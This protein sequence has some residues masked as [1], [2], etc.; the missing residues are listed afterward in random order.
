[1]KPTLIVHGGAG[2]FPQHHQETA[3]EG[4]RVAAEKGYELL[5]AGSSALDIVET[6]VCILED[7]PVFDSGVGSV[8]NSDGE[9]EQ[10]AIIMD[11]ATLGIGA[12]AAVKG[13]RNA[14]TLAR[15]VKDHTPHTLLVGDGA[16]RFARQQKLPLCTTADLTTPHELDRYLAHLNNIKTETGSK[17]TVGAVAVDKVGNI[18]AATSTGGIFFKMPGRVGDTPIVGAGAYADNQLGGASATGHGESIMR[19]LLSKTALDALTRGM[20]VQQAAE[21][22]IHVLHTRMQAQ[23]GIIMVDPAGN[24]GFAYNTPHMAVARVL[25]DGH[26][27]TQL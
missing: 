6:A 21:F 3:M 16:F 11:G 10:D 20:N 13:I 2:T 23:A 14:I 19:I 27:E 4:V 12:V 17:G 22:G 15:R 5:I 26:I 25:D 9:I 1:M 24:V 8:L 18:A 7:C